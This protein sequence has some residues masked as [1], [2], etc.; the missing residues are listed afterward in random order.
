KQAGIV[1]NAL[2]GVYSF[3]TTLFLNKKGEI[4]Q[5]HSG[6]DGP[7]TGVHFTHLKEAT[8][9]LLLKLLEE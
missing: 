5:V 1:F 8:E 3:P 7:G 4:V 2:N 9:A 6:F